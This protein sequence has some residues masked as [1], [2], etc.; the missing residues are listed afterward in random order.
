MDLV[1]D[2]DCEKV[3][4]DD[5]YERRRLCAFLRFCLWMTYTRVKSISNFKLMRERSYFVNIY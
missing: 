1:Y 3:S 5:V 4:K 2:G